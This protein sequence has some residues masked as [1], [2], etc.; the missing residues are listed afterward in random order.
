MTMLP[1]ATGPF[2]SLNNTNFV[3]LLGF[4]IFVG[5]LIYFKVPGMITG[6]LDKRAERIRAE[7]DEAR[8]LRDEA[9]AILASYARKQAEVA[10]QA[11][12]IVAHARAEAEA[13][14]RQAHADLERSIARRLRAAEDQIASAEAGAIREVKDK[15]VSIAVAA[16]A[17]VI[18]GGMK[19]DDQNRL[20]D[21][22]I[23]QVGA[24]L[25]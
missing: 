1:L 25:N 12:E 17:S 10:E 2:F 5:I 19:A 22:A 11:R 8:S 21:D 9:Q 14:A 7:L 24:R 4:L 20:I 15:A 13:A 18:T 23:R 3:V 6:L 16:A